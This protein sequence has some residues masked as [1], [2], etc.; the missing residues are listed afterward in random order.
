MAQGKSGKGSRRRSKP[1][2]DRSLLNNLTPQQI[3]VIA[4]LLTNALTV[5]S[6]LIDKEQ[7]LQIVLGG[8]LR[9]KTRLDQLINELQDASLDELL[10]SL[11]NR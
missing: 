10:D 11:L 5:D 3:A 1:K 2:Q 9:R 6:L 4:G 7:R 8:S